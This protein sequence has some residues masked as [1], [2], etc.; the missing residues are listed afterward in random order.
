MSGLVL[1][2]SI[3][4]SKRANVFQPTNI[5]FLHVVTQCVHSPS[6]QGAIQVKWNQDDPF[7]IDHGQGQ[8]DIHKYRITNTNFEPQLPYLF[9]ENIKRTIKCVLSL[10]NLLF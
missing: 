2:M 8:I 4:L 9:L 3:V 6:T 10:S 1:H 7:A 5:Y